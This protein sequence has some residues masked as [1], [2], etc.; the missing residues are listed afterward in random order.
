MGPM[1]PRRERHLPALSNRS[2]I[3]KHKRHISYL[4]HVSYNVCFV[5]RN[6]GLD[7]IAG[8][9]GT[10]KKGEYFVLGCLCS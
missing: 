3:N 4:C 10:A 9:C 8:F 7:P 6:K 5:V 2:N 1:G